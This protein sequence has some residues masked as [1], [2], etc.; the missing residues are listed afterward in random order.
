MSQFKE[1]IEYALN[2]I[3]KEHFDTD[4]AV[5]GEVHHYGTVHYICT[6][7]EQLN[8]RLKQFDQDEK[9]KIFIVKAEQQE[10]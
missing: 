9:V 5:E 3:E 2:A 8:A 4:E 1:A 10:P 7:T 6:N